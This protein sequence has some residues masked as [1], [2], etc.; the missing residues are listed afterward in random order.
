[1]EDCIHQVSS[2]ARRC[3]V[4]FSHFPY[5]CMLSWL[6]RCGS[7]EQN[8]RQLYGKLEK[9][10]VSVF[11]QSYMIQ[12]CRIQSSTIK[13]ALNKLCTNQFWKTVICYHIPIQ[14]VLFRTALP[15]YQDGIKN[16][17]W[18]LFLRGLLNNWQ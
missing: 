12:T 18:G 7:Q 14:T 1:M 8:S 11:Y 16:C 4:N 9:L 15:T 5:I 3:S 10:T 13:V 6:G 17:D 2:L